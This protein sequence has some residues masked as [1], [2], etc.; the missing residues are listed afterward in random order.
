MLSYSLYLR[1]QEAD[2][3]ADGTRNH[4]DYHDGAAKDDTAPT[5]LSDVS[6]SSLLFLLCFFFTVS[7]GRSTSPHMLISK[8]KQQNLDTGKENYLPNIKLKTIKSGGAVDDGMVLKP[9]VEHDLFDLS[10]L[11]D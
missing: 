9:P 1:I 5:S 8:K 6:S 4:R 3:P 10:E 11:D 2:A 7:H